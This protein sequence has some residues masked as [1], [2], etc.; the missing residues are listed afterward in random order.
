[1][2]EFN[3]A[4]KNRGKAS[5]RTMQ[6]NQVVFDAISKKAKKDPRYIVLH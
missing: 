5:Q 1:L 3:N 6:N 4:F 2:V